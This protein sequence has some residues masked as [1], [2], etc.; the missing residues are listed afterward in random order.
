MD[1]KI[2]AFLL[3]LTG[4]IVGLGIWSQNF[5][6]TSAQELFAHFDQLEQAI[7]QEHWN[8][9]LQKIDQITQIW[10]MTKKHWYYHLNHQEIDEID[11]TITRLK[12]YIQIQELPSAL[13]EVAALKLLIKH[14]PELTTLTLENIF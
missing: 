6:F 8:S 10:S 3:I 12:Q 5:I 14:I 2:I 7:A 1:L 13:A 11:L 9:S 4:A